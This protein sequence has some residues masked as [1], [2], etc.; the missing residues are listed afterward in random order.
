MP[1]ALLL[2]YIPAVAILGMSAGLASWTFIVSSAVC[3][4]TAIAQT[5]AACAG[6]AQLVSRRDLRTKLNVISLAV[7]A[8]SLLFLAM[9]GWA[10]Q[11]E[12]YAL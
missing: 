8:F 12:R 7:A 4:A 1:F 6:V 9:I 3:A 11:I 5:F 2:L 10:W